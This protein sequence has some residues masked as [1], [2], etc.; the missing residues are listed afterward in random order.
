MWQSMASWVCVC[1]LAVSPGLAGEVEREW[2]AAFH[3]DANLF[4]VC[5]VDTRHGWAVGDR[6]TILHTADGG[7]S[8]AVQ[9][10]PVACRLESVQFINA[11]RGWVVGGYTTP[12]THRAVGVLLK[13]EDGGQS[14]ARLEGQFLP[15]LTHVQFLDV[16][17]GFV[18][19]LASS[20][21]PS[22]VFHTQDG[23]QHW[24][25][26]PGHSDGWVHGQFQPRGVGLLL[27]RNGQL[28]VVE[29]AEVRPL[30]TPPTDPRLPLRVCLSSPQQ[31]LLCGN[32]GLVYQTRDGGRSW[33]KPR[34]LP[35]ARA[36][37]EFDW[38]ALDGI[39]PQFWM[40]GV[41]GSR[42]LHTPDGGASWELIDTGHRLPL[43][44]LDFVNADHGWAVGCAR[45]R[46]PHRGWG[47]QLELSAGSGAA[48]GGDGGIRTPRPDSL[49]TLGADSV[50][51]RG[52]TRRSK[53]FRLLGCVAKSRVGFHS[54]PD[55]T[56]RS[57][58]WVG[59][60]R[61]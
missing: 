12:Y 29:P 17:R 39:H 5:F 21:F 8:W 47:S 55:Y 34:E 50:P 57:C 51:V 24:T 44:G 45:Q 4:D 35:A 27:D 37:A 23:G 53:C 42:V 11:Q 38:L 25:A 43:F 10:S 40:V 32:Q 3:E 2:P 52:P 22:A 31:G 18:L 54:H 30:A 61:T 14:W 28:S 41:P 13:T 26:W 1:G 16:Q 60:E 48:V 49:G 33:Q 36:M 46:D 59:W 15:W 9:S 7:Q 20:M 58:S 19:G 56:R 6:G